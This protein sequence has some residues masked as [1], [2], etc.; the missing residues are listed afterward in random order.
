MTGDGDV[1]PLVLDEVLLD[2]FAAKIIVD[3]RGHGQPGRVVNQHLRVQVLGGGDQITAGNDGVESEEIVL[4]GGADRFIADQVAR[5]SA[6]DP[7]SAAGSDAGR[8]MGEID[9]MK[10]KMP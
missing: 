1:V 4:G 5:R 6:P 7:F 3:D 9:W 8:E 2:G 10:L